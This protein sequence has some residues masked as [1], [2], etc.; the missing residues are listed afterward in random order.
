MKLKRIL[1]TVAISVLLTAPVMAHSIPQDAVNYIKEQYPKAT[2]RFDSLIVLP[3][4]TEYLPILPSIAQYN[5]GMGI[6]VSSPSVKDLKSK[7]DMVVF[8][9][10][11][12]LLK[13]IKGKNDTRTVKNLKDYPIEI[14]TGMLP[15]ELIVPHGLILP[16]E[17]QGILGN[18]EIPLAP[19]ASV[20]PTT[21]TTT[22]YAH[23]KSETPATNKMQKMDNPKKTVLDVDQPA[24][25]RGKRYLVTNLNSEYINIIPS[26]ASD[27]KFTLRLESIPL[28]MAITTDEGFLLISK[29]NNT[30]IDLVDI[31]HEE[32]IKKIDLEVQPNEILIAPDNK[33]AYIT[34]LS[35]K[36]IFILDISNMRILQKIQVQGMPE[37]LALSNDNQ[38]L[39]YYD[40][41]SS[42]LYCLELNGRFISTLVDTYPNASK[43]IY[44]NDKVYALLRQSNELSIKDYTP[45]V[46]NGDE[47]AVKKAEAVRLKKEKDDIEARENRKNNSQLMGSTDNMDFSSA[48]QKSDV[49]K[50]STKTYKDRNTVMPLIVQNEEEGEQQQKIAV[51][52]KPVDMIG[53]GSNLYILAT[54]NKTIDIVD[55]ASGKM[56]GS[57][58]LPV[59][60][61]PKK[62]TQVKNSNIAL[63]TNV[64]DNSYVV[65]DLAA[66]RVVDVCNLS[67]PINNILIIQ[68]L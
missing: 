21:P 51:G 37:K 42:K 63:I 57:V 54:Q 19:M 50:S 16:E 15:Q 65:F 3:D 49:E 2:I 7:P 34:S 11:F 38:K 13:I 47:K 18:L 20:L 6:K 25:L 1:G 67:V 40:K 44:S 8:D 56:V 55:T 62:I 43:F 59:R 31:R 58:K 24:I 46:F 26:Y 14:K 12:A 23:P 64:A 17:L 52:T 61:F 60:G 41:I 29:I 10:N 5:A 28:D 36:S 9:N 22:N 53:Y 30:N 27:P 32:I 33:V 48:D 4:G 66:K 45:P 39:L 68:D 35:D